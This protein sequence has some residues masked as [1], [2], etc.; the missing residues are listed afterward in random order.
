MGWFKRRR[1]PASN[2]VASQLPQSSRDPVAEALAEAARGGPMVRRLDDYEPLLEELPQWVQVSPDDSLDGFNTMV[3]FSDEIHSYTDP[4][5]EGLEE[6]LADQPGIDDVFAE[7][8]ETVYLR[9]RLALAD[10]QA[11]VVRAVVE[12]NRNPRQRPPSGELAEEEVMALAD[13][14]APLFAGAGFVRGV[15]RFSPRYFHR[16]GEDGFVQ[17]VFLMPDNG[18]LSDGMRL[19]GRVMVCP[20]VRVPEMARD[21][22]PAGDVAMVAPADCALTWYAHPLPREVVDTVRSQTLP[23]LEA[24][25]GRAALARWVAEDPERIAVPAQ[26]PGYARVF[27][28]WGFLDAASSVLRN[29]DRDWPRLVDD[30][31][32]VEAR[33]ILADN[34]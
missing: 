6:A 23:L 2:R 10:V 16:A 26:R 11:A 25:R 30:P 27:A 1:S 22:R 19:A 24:T 13:Q 7:D 4:A 21:G 18:E 14:V 20:G 12:V 33:R 17:V 31:A 3:T 9:T 34:G 32:A 5:E 28:Q 29:L 15:G 8:R